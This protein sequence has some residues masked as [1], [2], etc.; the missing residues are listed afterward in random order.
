MGFNFV[1]EPHDPPEPGIEEV[2]EA[3]VH[4]Y[5]ALPEDLRARWDLFADM[6]ADEIAARVRQGFANDPSERREV[7]IAY[8]ARQIGYRWIPGRATRLQV[9]PLWDLLR[10]DTFA[11]LDRDDRHLL[12]MIA[13]SSRKVRRT[14]HPKAALACI[15][16]WRHGNDEERA[17]AEFQLRELG[18][19]ARIQFL[20]DVVRTLGRRQAEAEVDSERD[21][22][23]LAAMQLDATLWDATALLGGLYLVRRFDPWYTGHPLKNLETACDR[24]AAERPFEYAHWLLLMADAARGGELT[25]SWLEPVVEAAIR[26]SVGDRGHQNAVR[27]FHQRRLY[28]ATPPRLAHMF[29]DELDQIGTAQGLASPPVRA[30][31]DTLEHEVDLACVENPFRAMRLLELI[32]ARIHGEPLP[33]VLHATPQ[34][35]ALTE[36]L[37]TLYVRVCHLDPVAVRFV[38]EHYH[39]VDWERA[40]D[41]TP[42]DVEIYELVGD[43]EATFGAR[44]ADLFGVQIAHVEKDAAARV[45]YFAT[46][47]TD[48]NSIART[49]RQLDLP[50]TLPVTHLGGSNFTAGV[51]GQVLKYLQDHAAR[52]DERERVAKDLRAVGANIEHWDDIGTLPIS[53]IEAA[54][55]RGRQRDILLAAATGGAAGVLTPSTGGLSAIMDLPF[56][57]ALVADTCARHCWYYGFDPREHPDLTVEIVAVALGGTDARAEEPAIVRDRLRRYLV[58][59]SILLAAL[60]QGS[61]APLAGPMSRVLL[62]RFGRTQRTALPRLLDR[63]RGRNRSSERPLA[64]AIRKSLLPGGVGVLGAAFNVS[65]VYDLCES[66]EAVLADRFLARKYADWEG[67]F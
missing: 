14:L 37:L 2:S 8:L 39:Q 18:L 13:C 22:F 24:A 3:V 9:Q 49:L 29:S 61:L 28:D 1:D 54:L 7:L 32:I 45:R 60:G 15:A 35:D 56:V 19:P 4:A 41:A 6:D 31:L 50:E 26:L 12:W 48:A 46:A 17:G 43:Y 27:K 64:R 52:P 47:R 11:K 51:I 23:A 34:L 36:R 5:E 59:R 21:L 57:L 10:A 44:P 58:R 30:A 66:A 67:R 53:K 25:S 55:R 40:T 38:R 16:L 20:Y 63:V 62:D 65:L 33:V 42:D